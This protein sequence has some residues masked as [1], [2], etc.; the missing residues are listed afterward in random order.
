MP[1][2]RQA[3]WVEYDSAKL[4]PNSNATVG[5][6]EKD[7][8]TRKDKNSHWLYGGQSTGRVN[9]MADV[10]SRHAPLNAITK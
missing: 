2:M 7:Q 6:M 4:P 10:D 5:C 1:P 3:V 8:D 9:L